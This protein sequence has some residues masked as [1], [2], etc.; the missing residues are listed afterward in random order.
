MTGSTGAPCDGSTMTI[1][2]PVSL[3]LSTVLLASALLGT[4]C[5]SYTRYRP[6][7]SSPVA[8]SE[9]QTCFAQCD[10]RY[11]GHQANEDEY[12]SCV[13]SCPGVVQEHKSCDDSLEVCEERKEVSTAKVIAG[14]AFV[15]LTALTVA[16]VAAAPIIIL[17]TL[18]CDGVAHC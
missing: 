18:E 12:Y 2:T 7:D 17:S 5:H 3:F 14:G 15:A 8:Q 6:S 16:A 10:A 1:R 4:G 11:R 9:T 13:E